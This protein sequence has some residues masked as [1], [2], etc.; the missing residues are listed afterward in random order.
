MENVRRQCGFFNGVDVPADGTRGLVTLKSS[1]KNHIDVE[2]QEEEGN[3]RWKYTGKNNSLLW[4]VGDDFNDILFASEKQGRLLRDE[5]R[6]EAFRRT[7]EECHLEDI[8][9]S[10]K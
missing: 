7:L 9:Y 3:P 1:S 2:F 8:G 5:A 6:M 4:L 10:R